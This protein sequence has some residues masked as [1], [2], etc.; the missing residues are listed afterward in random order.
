M[1]PTRLSVSLLV[2]GSIALIAAATPPAA[3]APADLSGFLPAP[4][5][6]PGWRV[7]DPPRLF[8]GEELFDLIDGGAMLYQ[9]YGFVRA[10]SCRYAGPATASLQIE[11]YEMSSDGA[12]YGIYSMMQSARGA[13]VDAGQEARLFDD[14]IAVWKGP[15]YISVTA[16]GPREAVGAALPKMGRLIASRIPVTGNRPAI[17]GRLPP[18]GLLDRKY[19]RGSLA[20]SNVRV[21]GPGD[22]FRVREGACGLY[23]D[24]QVFLLQY[25]DAA[26]AAAQLAAARQSLAQE[27]RHEI[28]PAGAGGFDAV[29]ATGNRIRVR[30]AGDTIE[31][32]ADLPPA[33][34]VATP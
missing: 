18:D 13:A 10:L 15:Y 30:L 16:L 9:E 21:F 12:A 19:L 2:A 6:I 3:P 8:Q 1:T 31:V 28:A 11:I 26:R 27:G 29:D 14:Y 33:P 5:G 23:A 32:R 24:R 17:V 34:S 4:D 22:P 25:A 20:L 7:A